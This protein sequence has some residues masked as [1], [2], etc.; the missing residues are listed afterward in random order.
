MPVLT[1]RA[2]VR[3]AASAVALASA[4]FAPLGAS[5]AARASADVV[6]Y[7]CTGDS[8]PA[9][10][11]RLRVTLTMPTSAVVG[12]QFSIRW[13]G[14]YETGSELKAPSTGLPAGLNLYP[15]A[16]ISG[17]TGLTSATGAGALGAVTPGQ[18][19]TLP[20]VEMKATAR[21]PGTGSVRPGAVT[22]GTTE[23]EPLITCQ[24]ASTGQLSAYT[25][26]VAAGST[27]PD[28]TSSPDASTSGTPTS[29]GTTEEP[30]DSTDSTDSSG[31]S[32]EETTRKRSSAVPKAGAET[33]GGG[34]AGPDGR[35]LVLGGSALIMAAG[36]GGLL[37]R[38]PRR[39]T[40]R[41]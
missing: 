14:T 12:E 2:R 36:I 15:H 22:I 26:T 17:L 27:D 19:I 8:L 20:T 21:N 39:A 1:S 38:R 37:T 16:G 13:S 32:A 10:T 28:P 23:N 5:S 35:A 33:G 3:F 11:V 30:D 40:G 6:E 41:G 31:S 34:E 4:V 9:L 7:S 24:A 25:L 18:A 29:S